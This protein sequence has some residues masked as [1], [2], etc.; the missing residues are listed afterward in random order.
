MISP[1]TR[2]CVG[3]SILWNSWLA[4]VP[5]THTHTTHARAHGHGQHS[6]H[7]LRPQRDA[8]LVAVCAANLTRAVAFLNISMTRTGAHR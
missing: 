7:Q 3:R 4:R 2:S 8:S 1:R 5:H 6:C